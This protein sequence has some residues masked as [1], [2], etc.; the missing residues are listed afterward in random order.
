MKFM[1]PFLS[2]AF[3]SYSY[4][5]TPTLECKKGQDTLHFHLGS[6]NNGASPSLFGIRL[7][8]LTGN[9]GYQVFNKILA[10]S[11]KC[12]DMRSYVRI[13]SSEIYLCEGEMFLPNGIYG[14]VILSHG[15]LEVFKE[16]LATASGWNCH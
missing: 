15:A 7:N 3:A 12:E 13:T 1:I 9:E 14:Q 4:A 6:H 2:L 16:S 8:D 11:K 5:D 10:D